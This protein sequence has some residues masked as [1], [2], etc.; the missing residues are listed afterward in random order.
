MVVMM[1]VRFPLWLR[2][3]EDI[4]F[5]RGVDLCHET[6]RFWWSSLGPM[7]ASDIR[8]QRVSR[9]RG[10]THWRRRFDETY[11]K[12]IGEM[13][14]LWRAVDHEGESLESFVMKTHDKQAV[15]TFMKKTLKR[16]G[17]PEAITTD[18]LT[19]YRVAMK[20][21]SNTAEQEIDRW[22]NN[23][24]ANSHLPFRRRERAVL[25]FRQMKSL[26]KCRQRARQPPQSL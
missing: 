11:V 22:A 26:Q 19:S 1:Y 9:M 24:V 10:V 12:M 2:N 21:L 4:L 3:V 25:R 8:C 18:G 13:H 15:L 7:F 17:S 20:V 14:Y 23:R 5:E 6:V 16:H